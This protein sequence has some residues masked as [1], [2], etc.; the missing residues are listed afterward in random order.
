MFETAAAEHRAGDFEAA[1]RGYKM[2]L[3]S[4]PHHFDAMHM[5]GLISYQ[6]GSFTEA[7]RLLN[8]AIKKNPS[9][10]AIYTNLGTV[11]N[12]NKQPDAAITALQKAL[13]LSPSEA[14]AYNSLGNAYQLK[15][16][17]DQSINAYKK[18]VNI[19]PSFTDAYVNL[20]TAFYKS[21]RYAEA[22]KCFQRAVELDP[23]HSSARHMLA[24]LSGKTPENAPLDHVSKLFDD[25]STNFEEHLVR[26]LGYS[27]PKLI[28]NEIR[29]VTAK[30]VQFANTIDLGCGTGLAGIEFRPISTRLTGIDISERMVEKARAQ[31]VY[32]V[33][34]SGDILAY[35][36][37]SREKYDLFICTDVF[38][39]IG[40]IYPLFS[41]VKKCARNGAYFAFSTETTSQTDY[42]LRKTGRYA[43]SRD[44]IIKASGDIGFSVI[45][46]RTE[47]LRKQRG[48]WIQG[49]LII[50]KSGYN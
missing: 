25:Y 41:S 24:S 19:N 18:A 42:V 8:M 44:Y 48:S 26:D 15:D 30:E 43:H 9:N 3:E 47:N 6:R 21:S 49:D 11:Y 28:E 29:K 20:G 14:L 12:A 35:L 33:L 37:A 32:D 16:L 13:A 5:L 1:E 17:E 40:N 36:E 22:K 31:N 4:D 34:H 50:L 23:N 2:I 46:M 38:P 39:Y 7:I 45:T 10:A 27:M